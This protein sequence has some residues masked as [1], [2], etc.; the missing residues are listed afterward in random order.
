MLWVWVDSNDQSQ[1]ERIYSPCGYQLPVTHPNMK[2][3]NIA[4]RSDSN[5]NLPP[6]GSD[7]LNYVHDKITFLCYCWCI[8]SLKHVIISICENDA[9]SFVDSRGLEPRS[10]DFQ[11]S[12][13]TIS[14]KN[15][16]C[17]VSWRNRTVSFAVTVR[18]ANQ[19]HQRHHLKIVLSTH[20][21]ERLR[22]ACRIPHGTRTRIS[23]LKGWRTD[24]L[25][26]RDICVPRARVELARTFLS[27]RF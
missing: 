7:Q 25:F 21:E 20:H 10:L 16:W 22:S 2:K 27:I 14:A 5:G 3:R 24:L 26:E 15:P 4:E 9:I 1:R 23:T 12:A 13:Y 11:S 18:Y 6:R 19:L 8:I 17:W